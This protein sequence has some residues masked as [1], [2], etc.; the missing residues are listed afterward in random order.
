[1]QSIVFSNVFEKVKDPHIVLYGA[2]SGGISCYQYL[3]DIGLENAI[4]FFVDSDPLKHEK[5]LCGKKIVSIDFLK[6]YPDLLVVISSGYYREIHEKLRSLGC[7]NPVFAYLH[8]NPPFGNEIFNDDPRYIGSFYEEDPYTA[9]LIDA[10][11]YIRNPRNCRIQPADNAIALQA[12]ASYWCDARTSLKDYDALTICDVGAYDGDSLKQLWKDYGDKIRRAYAFE[13]DNESFEKLKNNI[14]NSDFKD[15][16]I[17]YKAG[18]GD[19]NTFLSFSLDEISANRHI[20]EE[21]ESK[22]EVKRLDDLNIEV[23]GKLCIKMDIEGAE[24]GAL[25]GAEG[26]IRT[27]KPDLAI[28]VYHKANDLSVI[29]EYIKSIDPGYGCILRGGVHMVCYAKY[30]Q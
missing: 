5:F 13:P 23:T 8:L 1:M 17:L 10:S 6:Q 2:S 24:M 11:I 30:R 29:P 14:Y 28:C 22:I 9:M 12:V 20:A 19:K 18:L 3:K 21:G 7:S 16:V 15:R 25:H 26:T 4:E 27:H